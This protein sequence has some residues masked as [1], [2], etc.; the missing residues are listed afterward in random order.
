MPQ[1]THGLPKAGSAESR[2]APDKSDLWA[3]VEALEIVVAS[4]HSGDDDAALNDEHRLYY[5]AANS[6]N[7][8]EDPYLLIHR[9]MDILMVGNSAVQAGETRH[10]VKIDAD[11]DY[12]KDT[13]DA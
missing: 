3:R 9:L 7:K 8:V 11:E 12:E 2:N 4:L 5:D 13:I 1:E 10:T 6:F